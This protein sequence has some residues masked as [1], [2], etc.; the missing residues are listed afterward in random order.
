MNNFTMCHGAILE[1]LGGPNGALF[2]R[3]AGTVA[4][5][6]E[7][8][9]AV[10]SGECPVAITGGAD[11]A[12]H[13]V[14]LAELA[15][16]GRIARGLLPA[17]GAALLALRPATD[18]DDIVIEGAAHASGR[19]R[20]IADAIMDALSHALRIALRP[21]KIDTVVLAPWGP[22]AADA[23]RSFV[24]SRMSECAV[25]DLSSHGE[26]LAAGVA[27]AVLA[28]VTALRDGRSKCVLVAALGVDGD[29][30]IVILSRGAAATC[31]RGA[32]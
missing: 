7:A 32:A 23:L 28:A 17:D 30:G 14:T 24:A 19:S 18:S 26:T 5:I 22:P 3:G 31:T 6:A 25:I 1:G 29:P 13:P 10:S 9:Y 4:A 15:R 11:V 21:Q 2:S 27:F 8:A 16:D 12:T 20:A